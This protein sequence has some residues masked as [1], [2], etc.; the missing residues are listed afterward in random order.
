VTASSL[1]AT[2]A[3]T[4]Y[5]GAAI[6]D[7][8]NLLAAELKRRGWVD[9]AISIAP[10]FWEYPHGM[11]QP[12]VLVVRRDSTVLESWAIVPSLVSSY[13]PSGRPSAPLILV[14]VTRPETNN[15][16]TLDEYWA[17]MALTD[18]SQMNLHGASDRP[19]LEQIWSNALAKEKGESA[20]H[21]AYTTT[22]AVD[23]L[24]KTIL[25]FFGW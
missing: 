9:V 10:R 1:E 3:S 25:G 12:A 7:P 22:W 16:E 11:A 21:E 5:T 2:R 20:P 14:H 23:L 8:E 18:I 24:Q 6:V 4:G 13:L 17:A 19:K 15:N